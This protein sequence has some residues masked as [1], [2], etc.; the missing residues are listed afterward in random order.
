MILDDIKDFFIGYY[1]GMWLRKNPYLFEIHIIYMYMY[2]T[3]VYYDVSKDKDVMRC[4][5]CFKLL[6]H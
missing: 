5:I 1:T 3:Y 2:Y 6:Q 4:G